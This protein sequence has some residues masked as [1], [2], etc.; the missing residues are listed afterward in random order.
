MY[1]SFA[2][3]AKYNYLSN[4]ATILPISNQFGGARLGSI[5]EIYRLRVLINS[6]VCYIYLCACVKQCSFTCNQ[7][8]ELVKSS[9]VRR[10]CSVT[11][12]NKSITK[13]LY[14]HLKCLKT[15]YDLNISNTTVGK[16]LMILILLT[17]HNGIKQLETKLTLLGFSSNKTC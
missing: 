15:N 2:K 6:Y 14:K 8:K 1:I 3:I 11:A 5:Q 13:I 12:S 10:V 9:F 17:T 7:W 16:K 4:L